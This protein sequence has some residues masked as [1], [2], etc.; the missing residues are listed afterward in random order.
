M[1]GHDDA[2]DL[3]PR[4]LVRIGLLAFWAFVGWGCLLLVF[5]LVDAMR[6]GVGPA[7]T[8]LLPLRDH[9]PW[10]WLNV[11]SAALALA[12]AFVVGGVAALARA[13]RPPSSPGGEGGPPPA[14]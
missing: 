3:V 14:P 9:S 11:L 8:R 4:S 10:A 12:V 7:L 1:D 5:A 13:Q 2:G 6:E